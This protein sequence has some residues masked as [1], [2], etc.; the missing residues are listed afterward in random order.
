[1]SETS[2]ISSSYIGTDES[3]KGDYFGPLVVAA[4]LVTDE[5]KDGLLGLDVKDSK[6]TTDKKVC[7]IAARIEAEY[8]YSVV[9]V[10]AEKYNDLYS[11]IRNLNRLLA[12]AHARAI[13]NLLDKCDVKLA[14][15]DQFGDPRY[16]E[17]ALMKKGREIR[18][19]QEVRAEKYIGVAAASIV[20]RAR[21]LGYLDRYGSEYDL[22]F[23]K[24]AGTNVDE[25]AAEFCR[26]YNRGD[27]GKVAKLHFKNTSKVERLLQVGR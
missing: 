2:Q 20:A 8:P 24:G 15:T 23:P 25:A 3:G 6:R 18:L 10:G 4:V 11:K 21:F 19:V 9:A 26:R 14:V 17:S 27:L 22:K 16:V 7:R 1:M 12:W 5:T 13:E